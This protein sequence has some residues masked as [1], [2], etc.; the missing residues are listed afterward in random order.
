MLYF[1]FFY[2][3]KM[4]DT[5]KLNRPELSEEEKV[6]VDSQEQVED[7][8][9]ELPITKEE[10]KEFCDALEKAMEEMKR[11]W[12]PMDVFLHALEGWI[13]DAKAAWLLKRTDEEIKK[14][15]EIIIKLSNSNFDYKNLIVK[16]EEI[17]EY[18]LN[19]DWLYNLVNN[20]L[21]KKDRKFIKKTLKA[22][23]KTRENE[24]K[25]HIKAEKKE[26]KRVTKARKD[27]I[28]KINS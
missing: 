3:N 5:E 7:L 16:N 17:G 24:K 20:N 26:L 14:T 13:N 28:N 1:L 6:I 8:K 4:T 9:N 19:P 22:I 27:E 23:A 12:R 2:Y 25:E 18:Y 10:A 11:A 21:D 15:Q